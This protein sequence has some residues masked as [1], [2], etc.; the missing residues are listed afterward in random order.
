MFSHYNLRS[1]TAQPSSLLSA[2]PGYQPFANSS[3]GPPQTSSRADAVNKC[4]E[5]VT[6]T[7]D[8]LLPL[9]DTLK[10]ASDFEI[11]ISNVARLLIGHLREVKLELHDLKQMSHRS[12]S[13]MDGSLKDI[14]TGVVKTEQ[15]ARRDTI[16]VV[17]VAQPTDEKPA[18]LAEKVAQQLSL[19][20]ET[21]APSDFSTLHRNGQAREI[22]GKI[23]PPT[24]TVKFSKVSKK[25]AVLRGYRNFDSVAKKPRNIKVYQSLSP[26]YAG[27][28]QKIVKFFDTTNNNINHGKELKWA[29]YQSPTA[30]LVVRL[31]SEE[32]IKGIHIWD[33][34]VLKFGD[35]V[36]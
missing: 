26:H 35:A 27:L 10:P 25:D 16:T 6:A 19:S 32:Y 4:V 33:D 21:V 14:T 15:Y 9:L 28:R 17:G 30:G 2:G 18:A 3:N 11:G 23:V 7:L 36:A 24:I 31:K 34:F 12:F 5:T 22:R 8:G 29:T 13:A 20:G 1:Q